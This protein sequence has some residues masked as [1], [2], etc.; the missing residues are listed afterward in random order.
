[1]LTNP[2]IKLTESYKECYN[3]ADG[4]LKGRYPD[5]TSGADHYYNPDLANPDWAKSSRLVKIGSDGR[6]RTERGPSIHVFLK[7]R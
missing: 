5:P 3:I 2:K 6:I 4:V 7:T 1:M